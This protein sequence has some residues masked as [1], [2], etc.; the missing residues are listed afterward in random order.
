[1][2]HSMMRAVTL[3]V[4]VLLRANLMHQ[5]A[6]STVRLFHHGGSLT[7][8]GFVLLICLECVVLLSVLSLGVQ[9]GG[10]T[11]RYYLM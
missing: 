11:L 6:A 3:F 9:C 5:A 1:M 2:L 8:V 10:G 7:C 4:L